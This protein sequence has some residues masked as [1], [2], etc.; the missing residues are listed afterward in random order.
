M[1]TEFI[2]KESSGGPLIKNYLILHLV[3]IRKVLKIL[4]INKKR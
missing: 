1:V 4:W 2:E 3:K